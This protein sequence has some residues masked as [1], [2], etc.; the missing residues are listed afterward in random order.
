MYHTKMIGYVVGCLGLL[1]VGAAL[2]KDPAQTVGPSLSVP[3][4]AGRTD[5]PRV[6]THVLRFCGA[7]HHWIKVATVWPTTS[8]APLGTE[9]WSASGSAPMARPKTGAVSKDSES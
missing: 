1:T 9:D 5:S 7:T 2:A 6:R 4:Q 3:A 8:G